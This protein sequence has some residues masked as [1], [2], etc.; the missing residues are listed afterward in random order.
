MTSHRLDVVSGAVSLVTVVAL[1]LVVDGALPALAV[2][3]GLGAALL[4]A[5]SR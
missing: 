4:V 5:G 3:I 2:V 1:V